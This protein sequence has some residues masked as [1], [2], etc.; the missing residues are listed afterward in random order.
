M[1][2][3]VQIEIIGRVR[4][5][6]PE[7]FGIPRQPGLVKSSSGRLELCSGYDREEMVR[8]LE[9][10][11]HLWLQFI[12]HQAVAEGWRPTVRPPWLG[13]QKRVGVFAS[14]SPHRPNFLGMSV[15]RLRGIS[16]VDGRLG[17]DLSEL[18]LM[19][20]TPVVDFKPYLPYSDSLPQAS[21]GFAGQVEEVHPVEFSAPAQLF[22]HDYEQRTG[23]PLAALISET[24]AQDPRPASQRHHSR[25]YGMALWDVNVR[26]QVGAKGVFV[27]EEISD[28][29]VSL[30]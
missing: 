2:N 22:C 1:Q 25:S 5:C 4:S 3:S 28:L 15:V 24:L 21:S 12:F 18:D 6:Y 20:G 17:L 23:R 8:G 19:D 29:K 26:W 9:G 30:E 14:R 27:V 13:G 7:K 11:S 10:F 16:V